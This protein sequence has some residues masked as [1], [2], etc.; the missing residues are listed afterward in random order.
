MNQVTEVYAHYDNYADNHPEDEI[1][2]G[3]GADHVYYYE[4]KTLPT[5]I[6]STVV[7][8]NPGA[9]DDQQRGFVLSTCAAD[10][11]TTVSTGDTEEAQPP[12]EQLK[13]T[14]L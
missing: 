12:P 9:A 4:I 13:N 8:T 1:V 3:E 6:T 2:K 7:T 11:P 14:A 5:A 10:K